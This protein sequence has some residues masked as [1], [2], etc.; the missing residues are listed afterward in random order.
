VKIVSEI[1][2]IV[3]GVASNSTSSTLY[4]STDRVLHSFLDSR[5]LLMLMLVFGEVTSTE[6]SLYSDLFN[7]QVNVFTVFCCGLQAIHCKLADVAAASWPL[8]VTSQLLSCDDI[9]EIVAFDRSSPVAK[10]Q[11]CFQ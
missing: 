10:Y 8:P 5:V 9:T 3:L 2:A 1:T 4:I 6:V 11:F 7:C